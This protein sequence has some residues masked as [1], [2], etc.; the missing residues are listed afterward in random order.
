MRNNLKFIFDATFQRRLVSRP[1]QSCH[2]PKKRQSFCLIIISHPP[3]ENRS[4]ANYENILECCVVI[5]P[6]KDCRHNISLFSRPGNDS[7]M[8]CESINIYH[9]TF[10]AHYL[11][12][13]YL[14]IKLSIDHYL[15][16]FKNEVEV[17]MNYLA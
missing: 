2:P 9:I 17:E 5:S 14:T 4:T 13:V 12:A 10:Y 8:E 3:T 7:G 1:P 6:F 16:D 11:T 15:L